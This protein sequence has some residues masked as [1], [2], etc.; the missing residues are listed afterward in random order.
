MKIGKPIKVVTTPRRKFVK[1]MP[2]EQ[3]AG[4]PITLPKKKEAD[5]TT[6]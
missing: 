2:K 5:V 3:P 1:V 4:I 6:K